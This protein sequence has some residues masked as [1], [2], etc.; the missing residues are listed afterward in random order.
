MGWSGDGMEWNAGSAVKESGDILPSEDS[1]FQITLVRA[2][3][4]IPMC[5]LDGD[6]IPTHLWFIIPS[7]SQSAE[8]TKTAG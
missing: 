1:S 3:E 4:A 2:K 5:Q 7:A 6:H 8:L